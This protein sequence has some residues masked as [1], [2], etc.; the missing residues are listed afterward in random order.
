[1]TVE[2][3]TNE[4]SLHGFDHPMRVIEIYIDVSATERIYFADFPVTHYL[5]GEPVKLA[6]AVEN[7]KAELLSALKKLAPLLGKSN[8]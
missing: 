8:A 7:R 3:E 6:A 2:I 1:M 4:I 5:E